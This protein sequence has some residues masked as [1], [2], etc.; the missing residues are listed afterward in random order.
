MLNEDSPNKNIIIVGIQDALTFED[1]Y[2]KF[3][4]LV[5]KTS[6]S[7]ACEPGCDD[8]FSGR[9]GACLCSGSIDSLSKSIFNM[10]SAIGRIFLDEE[11]EEQSDN[12]NSNSNQPGN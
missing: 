9:S 6:P 7:D 2:P 11:E 4:I 10:K 8:A 3:D 1:L 12:N 5:T